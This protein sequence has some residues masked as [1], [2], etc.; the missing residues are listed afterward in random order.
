MTQ[1]YLDPTQASG[2]ALFMRGIAGPI[3]MLNLLRFREV[4]DYAAFPE[5]APSVPISGREAYQCY[6]DETLP[7]LAATGG[8]ILFLGEGGRYLIGPDAERWDLVMLIRQNSLGDFFRFASNEAYQQVLKH[9]TA[10][11]ADSRLLPLEA[12]TGSNISTVQSIS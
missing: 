12:Y 3:V 4:A 7:F 8:E 11:L 10:A 9:R 2:Q 6:I 5:V 1:V